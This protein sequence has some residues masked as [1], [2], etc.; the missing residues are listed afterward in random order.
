MRRRQPCYAG[1]LDG[2]REWLAGFVAAG[3][4]HLVLRFTGAHERH[5]D[6]FAGIGA[7][8]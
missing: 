2:A 8:L 4:S 7:T 5:L 1:P 3:A 6:L